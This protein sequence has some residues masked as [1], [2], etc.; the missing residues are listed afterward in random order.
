MKL[1]ARNQIMGF[2]QSVT[3]GNG[4]VEVIVDIGGNEVLSTEVMLATN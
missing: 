3:L 2:V 4:M 1:S